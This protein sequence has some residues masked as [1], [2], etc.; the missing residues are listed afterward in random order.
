MKIDN[1]TTGLHGEWRAV[2]D[3]Q[4]R[5]LFLPGRTAELAL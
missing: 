1:Q 3:Q 5:T 4:G 2:I